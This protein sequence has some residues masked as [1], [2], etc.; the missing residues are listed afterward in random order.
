MTITSVNDTSAEQ[1]ENSAGP[2]FLC[3]SGASMT[4]VVATVSLMSVQG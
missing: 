2:A 3:F 1:V 4:R